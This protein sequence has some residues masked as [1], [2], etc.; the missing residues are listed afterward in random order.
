L[1]SSSNTYN[2]Q[3]FEL[4]FKPD[5]NSIVSYNDDSYIYPNPFNNFLNL[6]TDNDGQLFIYSPEGQLIYSQYF[7]SGNNIINTANWPAGI[8]FVIFVSNDFVFSKKIIK[9][10]E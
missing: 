4:V 10:Y 9:I 6:K 3:G 1:F 7:Y 5:I 2:A 8:Y